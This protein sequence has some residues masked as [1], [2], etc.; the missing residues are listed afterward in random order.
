M[1]SRVF[2]TP[3]H[4]T[5][6]MTSNKRHETIIR[7]AVVYTRPKTCTSP[8]HMTTPTLEDI[9]KVIWFLTDAYRHSTMFR[10]FSPQYNFQMYSL[11]LILV[12]PATWGRRWLRSHWG[13]NYCC[14]SE[15]TN[16]Y[17]S[18]SRTVTW[19]NPVNSVD[20]DQLLKTPNTCGRADKMIVVADC[21]LVLV[22][23][24]LNKT[25]VKFVY[26][27]I[28]AAKPYVWDDMTRDMGVKR[29]STRPRIQVSNTIR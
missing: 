9:S 6:Y 4:V 27:Q 24:A 12:T 16:N 3:Y 14:L 7:V 26:V 1:K 2:V 28:T 29:L 18:F 15:M 10:W 21:P 11:R 22:H 19:S 23:L 25:L 8:S 13:I 5:T 20:S 17:T